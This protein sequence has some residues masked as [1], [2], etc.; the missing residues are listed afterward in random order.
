M[1]KNALVGA[2]SGLS[3]GVSFQF[4]AHTGKNGRTRF[5][6]ENYPEYRRA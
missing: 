5:P 1:P 2:S 4:S 6:A 3:T